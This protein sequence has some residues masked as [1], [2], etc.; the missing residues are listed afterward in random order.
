LSKGVK[1]TMANTKIE[2]LF[3]VNELAEILGWHPVTVY[4]WGARGSIPGRRRFGRSVRYR[5]S[6]IR[7]WIRERPK[8]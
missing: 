3:T 4:R 8:N 7:K 2:K 5:E 1:T 6:A